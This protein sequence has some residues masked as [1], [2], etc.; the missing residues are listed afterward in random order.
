MLRHLVPGEVVAVSVPS[1]RG[2]VDLKVLLMRVTLAGGYVTARS[3][4]LRGLVV[5]LAAVGPTIDEFSSSTNPVVAGQATTLVWKTS[6]ATDV[7]LDGKTVAVEGS[8]RVVLSETTRYRLTASDGSTTVS[9]DLVVTALPGP[10]IDEFRASSTRYASGAVPVLFWRTRNAMKATLTYAV[11]GT[12]SRTVVVPLQQQDGWQLEDAVG[13][14]RVN[15]VV[16]TVSNTAGLS[17]SA[18]IVLERL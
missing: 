3:R 7:R 10:I 11:S 4:L 12:R 16:L 8:A 17:V 18:R 13:G 2:A 14:R 5:E 6:G 15:V 9:T 1:L